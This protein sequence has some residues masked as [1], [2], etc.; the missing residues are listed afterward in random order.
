[1]K[2]E[3]LYAEVD[4]AQMRGPKWMLDVPAITRGR[5]VRAHRPSEIL[6]MIQIAEERPEAEGEKGEG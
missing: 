5:R 6:P 3:I 1:M 4:P 2:E